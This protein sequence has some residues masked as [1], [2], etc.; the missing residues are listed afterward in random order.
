MAERKW[1]TQ[2]VQQL[3]EVTI[4]VANAGERSLGYYV[5]VGMD[6]FNHDTERAYPAMLEAVAN[7]LNRH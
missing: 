4:N 1:T 2:D 3:L 7:A 5:R 6:Y